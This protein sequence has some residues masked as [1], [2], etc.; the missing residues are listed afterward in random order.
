MQRV[1]GIG[2]MIISNN[3]EDTI[4]T[5]ALASCVGI[6]VY[7]P[8]RRVGG[9]IHVVLPEP[10]A[11]KESDERVC[12]YATTGIPLMISKICNDYKCTKEELK[13]SLYGGANSIRS[14]DIF[15]VGKRNLHSIRNILRSMNLR[16]FDIET[17][18][19]VSRT[20][21]LHIKTGEVIISYQ[22]III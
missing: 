19:S 5:F 13:I 9:M 2:E 18:K 14:V 22:K 12:Y 11:G 4:K 8:L 21:E 10:P 1:V 17:G 6:V 16:F 15:N 3:I 7:S 20:I